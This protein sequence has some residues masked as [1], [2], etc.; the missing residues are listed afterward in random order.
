[1]RRQRE[2]AIAKER[3]LARIA[4]G[5][6]SSDKCHTWGAVIDCTEPSSTKRDNWMVKLRVIDPSFNFS[7]TQAGPAVRFLNYATIYV[8]GNRPE[9]L[10]EVHN[11]GDIIRLRRFAWTVT[12]FGEMHGYC[13]E[14]SNWITFDGTDNS[15]KP[16]SKMAITKNNQRQ[17][18][19]F[20]ALRLRDLRKWVRHFFAENTIRQVAWWS[21]VK[22]PSQLHGPGPQTFSSVDL[23]LKAQKVEKSGRLVRFEDADGVMFTL[24]SADPI[25][26]EAGTVLKMKAVRVIL[27][28]TGRTL[29]MVPDSSMLVVP[30]TSLD[31]RGFDQEYYEAHKERFEA[32]PPV[33]RSKRFQGGFATKEAVL[34]V[35]PYLKDYY[36]EEHLINK[37]GISGREASRK[38]ISSDVCLVHKNFF[39]KIPLKMSFLRDVQP[40]TAQKLLHEKFIVMVQL[41]AWTPQRPE[42]LLRLHCEGCASNRRLG[43][44]NR[45][46][47]GKDMRL[48]LFV[49][50]DVRD[51]SMPA[52]E[53]FPLYVTAK[54]QE[55]NVFALWGCLPDLNEP[56]TWGPLSDEAANTWLAKLDSLV[57]TQTFM[58]LCVQAKQTMTGK[59]FL[60]LC[61]SY[62]LP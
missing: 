9:E 19:E 34:K 20:E 62:L 6:G 10:P 39:N 4:S 15:L 28:K 31:A 53:V 60:E 33:F 35:Y 3:T 27:S 61:D 41:K 36:F 21:N 40:P 17:L 42:E 38:V 30:P 46:C 14:Y 25:T 16:T 12:K 45:T 55:R 48:C 50:L 54:T 24:E 13:R 29:E 5:M 49:R 59:R 57:Q 8:Y 44:A 37:P 22:V 1:M 52:E 18:E 26:L 2:A 7:Q 51:D 23:I 32:K 11:L 56:D 58:T 43:S 47:C